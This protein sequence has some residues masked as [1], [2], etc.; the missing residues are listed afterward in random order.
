M[1]RKPGFV[2]LGTRIVCN[3]GADHPS[4]GQTIWGQQLDDGRAGLAWDWIEIAHGVLAMA[5]PLGVV[6]N[7]RLISEHGD[8]L[9]ADEAALHIS[10]LVRRLPWQDEVSRVLHA[11]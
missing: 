7:L 3:G 8:V 1:K 2:H 10:R 11:A 6:T 5:D 4:T 9:T